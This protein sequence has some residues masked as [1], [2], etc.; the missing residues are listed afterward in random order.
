MDDRRVIEDIQRIEARDVMTRGVVTVET[1]LRID[2]LAAVLLENGIW[3]APVVDDGTLVGVV[4]LMDVVREE[5]E[6]SPGAASAIAGAFYRDQAPSDGIWKDYMPDATISQLRVA[7]I[8]TAPAI[9]FPP[10]ARLL[11][12]AE[13]M[14]EDGIH[15]VVIAQDGRVEGLVTTTDVMRVLVDAVRGRV[16]VPWM[17]AR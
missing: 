15:R 13:R 9:S 3:G 5:V 16:P 12:L 4:S 8:M 7:D 11:E 2:E 14:M 17:G 6:A 10:D 1:G